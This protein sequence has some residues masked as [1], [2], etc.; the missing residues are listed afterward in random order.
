MAKK[1]IVHLELKAGEVALLHN[2]LL[3]SSDVNKTS[4]ARRAFSV[5]YLDAR[6]Q[7][8]RDGVGPFTKIFEPEAAAD[9]RHALAR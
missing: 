8:D 2:W 9:A 7:C 6:T 1:D 3:H 5:C 4:I